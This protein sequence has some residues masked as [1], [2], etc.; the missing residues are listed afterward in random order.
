MDSQ[1]Q[2]E[3]A[4]CIILF[5]VCFILTF[6]LEIGG[7]TTGEQY[8]MHHVLSNKFE[9]RMLDIEWYKTAYD[10]EDP[11]RFLNDY[12]TI[13]DIH[14]IEGLLKFARYAVDLLYPI[15]RTNSADESFYSSSPNEIAKYELQ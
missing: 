13:D 15:N 9:N 6:L 5:T 12:K 1:G 8:K 10:E 2:S 14:D 4:F 3:G 7:H 11:T